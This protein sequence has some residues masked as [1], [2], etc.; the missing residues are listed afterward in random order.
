MNPAVSTGTSVIEC[1][2][3][4]AD[5]GGVRTEPGGKRVD[6]AFFFQNVHGWHKNPGGDGHFLDDIHQLPFFEP[7]RKR[8][9]FPPAE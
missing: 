4:D 6:P 9:D 3:S 8:A 2:V 1:A 5:H 7:P